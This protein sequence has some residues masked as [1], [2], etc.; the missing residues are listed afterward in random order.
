MK[1][2][3]QIPYWRPL[4]LISYTST[5]FLFTVPPPLNQKN[6]ITFHYK[7]CRKCGFLISQLTLVPKYHFAKYTEITHIF[8]AYKTGEVF[9]ANLMTY[10]RE[11]CL[12]AFVLHSMRLELF[13][14]SRITRISS[15]RISCLFMLH[16][17]SCVICKFLQKK[18]SILVW[19]T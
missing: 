2:S 6:P 11:K 10:S 13:R 1:N 14:A 5:Y 18:Y 3:M 12:R 7:T 4:T 9:F 8:T 15:I 16:F 17:D 19:V